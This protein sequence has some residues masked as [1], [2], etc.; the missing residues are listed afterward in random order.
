M[1]GGIRK[2]DTPDLLFNPVLKV[3]DIRK[4]E[5]GGIEV[6]VKASVFINYEISAS[7][8]TI[9]I[10]YYDSK[11]NPIGKD[12][13]FIIEMSPGEIKTIAFSDPPEAAISW[14]VWLVNP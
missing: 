9:N 14:R 6:V 12:G 7:L 3:L 1:K 13:R 2:A 4:S 10:E 11:G 5:K 8:R